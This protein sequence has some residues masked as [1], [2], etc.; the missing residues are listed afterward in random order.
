MTASALQ[1]DLE[2]LTR[3]GAAVQPVIID[4]QSN[5]DGLEALVQQHDIVI[6][7]L[8]YNLHPL[9]A[10]MCIKHHTNMVTSSYV[11]PEM[12]ALNQPYVCKFI[13]L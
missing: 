3:L 7:L 5:T 9:V 10:R 4:I 12:A 8:P 2:R 13:F 6:S 1:V 11:S